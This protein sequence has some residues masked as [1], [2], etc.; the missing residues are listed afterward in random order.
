M[1]CRFI[2]KHFTVLLFWFVYTYLLVELNVKVIEGP[3]F[4]SL[5]VDCCLVK[6][7][8]VTLDHRWVCTASGVHD[9]SDHVTVPCIF[10]FI[11]HL[12]EGRCVEVSLLLQ[13]CRAL[14]I[15]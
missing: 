2:V 9:N 6:T 8:L 14:A 13:L 5:T 3:P 4:T 7:Q 15:C 1:K 12:H 10:Y 11:L